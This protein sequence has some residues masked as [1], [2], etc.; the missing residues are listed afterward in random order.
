MTRS[1]KMQILASS[2]ATLRDAA[3]VLRAEGGAME[4]LTQDI[5]LIALLLTISAVGIAT[6]LV[7]LPYPVALVLT[8]GLLGILLRT[9]PLV[10]HA[11]LQ[12]LA[13][14]PHLIVVLFLPALLFEAT[15]HLEATAL[16]KTLLPIGLLALPGV[17]FSAGIVGALVHWGVG[18]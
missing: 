10:P 13:L 16:R 18:L 12:Q 15:L 17:L 8:G 9:L 1:W 6:R 7:Q 2:A 3:D 5:I 14:T 11:W 4:P